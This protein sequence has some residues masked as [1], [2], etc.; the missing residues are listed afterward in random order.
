MTKP[1]VTIRLN[2]NTNKF[3]K[4]YSDITIS[5]NHREKL[6]QQLGQYGISRAYDYLQE[7]VSSREKLTQKLLKHTG[8]EKLLHLTLSHFGNRALLIKLETILQQI[9][10]AY[11]QERQ[12]LQREPLLQITGEYGIS[13]GE[14]LSVKAGKSATIDEM[15]PGVLERMQY[16]QAR[17]NNYRRGNSITIKDANVLARCHGHI[18]DRVQKAKE[19]LYCN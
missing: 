7:R 17:A 16:W 2:P 15:I 9:A 3:I 6:L 12:H 8:I 18:F 14:R 5:P 11:C 13:C 4:P 10:A 1:Q 19:Y